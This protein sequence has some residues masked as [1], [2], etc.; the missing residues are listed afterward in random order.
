MSFCTSSAMTSTVDCAVSVD[1][2][3]AIWEGLTHMTRAVWDSPTSVFRLLIVFW[4]AESNAA[5]VAVSATAS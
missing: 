1:V 3:T 4:S 2:S 5:F